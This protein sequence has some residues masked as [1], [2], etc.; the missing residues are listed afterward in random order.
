MLTIGWEGLLKLE[1]ASL[2]VLVQENDRRWLGK[3][4]AHGP[5]YRLNWKNRENNSWIDA[6][7]MV[8]GA[9]E[10]FVSYHNSWNIDLEKS[11][12]PK[13]V[14]CIPF[15]FIRPGHNVHGYL[16]SL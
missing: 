13:V 16:F 11:F 4:P 12:L 3:V 14:L 5:N 10:L 7:V 9:F 6:E 15:L 8:Y 2:R 1:V